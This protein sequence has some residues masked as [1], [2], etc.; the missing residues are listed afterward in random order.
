MGLAPELDNF[1]V[2][3]GFNSLGI[4]MGG[5]VGRV[6]AEWI[7]EG[8]PDVDVTEIDIARMLPFENTP[9]YLKDRVSGSLLW[10]LCWLGISRLVCSRGSGA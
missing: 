8:I 10:S 1:Y 9:A 3:A 4:L 5:G 2:A 7:V 6:M